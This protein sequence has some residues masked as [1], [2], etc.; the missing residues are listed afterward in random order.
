MGTAY[1]TDHL[2]DGDL[3]SLADS[4]ATIVDAD[5]NTEYMSGIWTP[6]EH[7]LLGDDNES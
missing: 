3:E 2:T 4:D 1:C 7:M 5:E 6:I